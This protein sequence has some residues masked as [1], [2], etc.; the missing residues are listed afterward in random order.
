MHEWGITQELTEQIKRQA[1]QN[2]INTVTKV[3]IA[4]GK[5]SDLA[6]QDLKMC[7]EALTQDDDILKGC[8]LQIKK[9]LG[10]EI[11]INRI[12]GESN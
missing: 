8:Q 7:F 6:E 4:L 9:T 1:D 12:E 2:N 10:G 11:I 5:D 3:E